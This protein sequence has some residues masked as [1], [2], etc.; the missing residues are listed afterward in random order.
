MPPRLWPSLLSSLLAHVRPP[1]YSS[2]YLTLPS[3]SYSIAAVA[4][5]IRHPVHR[6][7]RGSCSVAAGRAGLA[8]WLP[9]SERS[10]W[11]LAEPRDREEDSAFW[12]V[13]DAS[14]LGP[15]RFRC[16]LYSHAMAR[17]HRVVLHS[18]Q[19]TRSPRWSRGDRQGKGFESSEGSP[20]V[21]SVLLLE[22][23]LDRTPPWPRLERLV[24]QGGPTGVSV[25]DVADEGVLPIALAVATSVRRLL[26]PIP[27]PRSNSASLSFSWCNS[28][29]RWALSNK[30][31]SRTTDWVRVCV[32]PLEQM[33][34]SFRE[35]PL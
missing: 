25:S 3:P 13:N 15:T 2:Q 17:P 29:T 10:S 20:V 16:L 28:L 1:F 11:S 23:C 12:R 31:P 34:A 22:G 6:Y 27:V 9:C 26:F 21:L 30:Q 19:A 14:L 7:S 32:P 18:P 33:R 35:G 8:L 5:A 24:A 4:R